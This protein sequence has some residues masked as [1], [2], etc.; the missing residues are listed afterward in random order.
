[1]LKMSAIVGLYMPYKGPLV[2]GF[3]V[4]RWWSVQEVGTYGRSL[5][6]LRVCP[7]MG[8]WDLSPVLLLFCSLAMK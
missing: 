5:V 8:W 6:L 1:M 4:E 3:A 2:N 7:K